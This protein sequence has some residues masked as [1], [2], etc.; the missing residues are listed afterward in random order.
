MLAACDRDVSAASSRA[1]GCA[2]WNTW[3]AFHAVWFN[4]DVPA[5]PLDDVKIRRISACFKEGAYK[6]HRMYLP[7]AKEHRVLALTGPHYWS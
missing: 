4:S 2:L 5:I 6:G 3:C 1:A 7:K